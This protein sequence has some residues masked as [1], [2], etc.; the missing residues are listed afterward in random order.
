MNVM[1]V[2][3]EQRFSIAVNQCVILFMLSVRITYYYLVTYH[4]TNFDLAVFSKTY[5]IFSYNYK[6]C[7]TSLLVDVSLLHSNF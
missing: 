4:P 5:Q 1:N 7:L 6:W 2:M 3:N